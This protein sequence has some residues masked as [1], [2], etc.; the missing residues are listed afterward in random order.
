MSSGFAE[1]VAR[2]HYSFLEGSSSPRALVAE[3]ARLEIPALGICDRNG[4]Y[5]AVAFVQEA[6]RVGIHPIIGTELDLA[7]GQSIRL[8]ARDRE[9]YRQLCR[10]ISAAQLA[11]EK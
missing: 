7:D 1:L 8:V 6:R 5:G 2:S 4:L 3:A 11:G 9:G 10:A